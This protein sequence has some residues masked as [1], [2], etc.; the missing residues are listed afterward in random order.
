MG[1][2][3][4]RWR[5]PGS[6][7]RPG[8][9]RGGLPRPRSH[10]VVGRHARQGADGARDPRASPGGLSEHGDRRAL[11]AVE[12]RRR[13]AR[14]RIFGVDPALRWGGLPRGGEPV[15]VGAGRVRRRRARAARGGGARSRARFDATARHREAARARAPSGRRSGRGDRHAD[16]RDRGARREQPPAAHVLRDRRCHRAVGDAPSEAAARRRGPRRLHRGLDAT[17]AHLSRSPRRQQAGGG[18]GRRRDRRSGAPPLALGALRARL[19]VP[20]RRRRG[21]RARRPRA[22]AHRDQPRLERDT[23]EPCRP[24]DDH[25]RARGG[26]RRA[27]RLRR[28]PRHRPTAAPAGLRALLLDQGSGQ[29]PRSP[30]RPRALA[31]GRRRRAHRLRAGE[32]YDGDGDAPRDGLRASGRRRSA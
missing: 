2:A 32:G 16:R 19:A 8:G 1:G 21:R 7:S 6:P 18:A 5:L 12:R 23:G 9:L 15:R 26:A 13:R 30:V 17:A 3:R 28:R 11:S 24:R 14:L 31:R 10:H 4:R 25:H 29:R 20:R 22:G 27:R